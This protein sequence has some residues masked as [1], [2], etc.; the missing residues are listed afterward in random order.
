MT[1][2]DLQTRNGI[3]GFAAGAAYVYELTP[4]TPVAATTALIEDVGELLADGKLDGGNANALT[5]KL[6][7]ALASLANGNDI[8]AMNQ[9]LAFIN[10]VQAMMK[11]KNPKL[12]IAKGQA[13]IDAATTV[14]DQ[15]LAGG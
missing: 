11:G 3:L 6:D 7:D 14:V 2:A 4:P 9:L 10:Q 12:S 5:S 8:A 13:L 1:S 15:I